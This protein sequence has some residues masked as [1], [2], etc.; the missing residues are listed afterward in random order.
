MF[1]AVMFAGAAMLLLCLFVA[2]VEIGPGGLPGYV[3]S[4]GMCSAICGMTIAAIVVMQVIGKQQYL[5]HGLVTRVS[6]IIASGI[7]ACGIWSAHVQQHEMAQGPPGAGEF[8]RMLGMGFAAVM[9]I[10]PGWGM[11]LA[12][13]GGLMV[14]V[15]SFAPLLATKFP[16]TAF[17]MRRVQQKK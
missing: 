9:R 11:Y 5:W 3:C 14:R 15:G 1:D 16:A 17:L 6:A 8:G 10:Q 4:G 2:W 13:F 7:G 12:V